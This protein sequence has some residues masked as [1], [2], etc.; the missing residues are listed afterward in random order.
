MATG[1]HQMNAEP[2]TDANRLAYTF[3]HEAQRPGGSGSRTQGR[4]CSDEKD[5][6][7]RTDQA[8]TP[9]SHCPLGQKEGKERVPLRRRYMTRNTFQ[10][11]YVF[12]RMTGHGK[13]HF[14]RYRVRSTDGKWRHLAETVNPPRRKD[15]ERILAER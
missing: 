7:R 2:L 8:W 15:A 10:K 4:P 1:S 9:S 6:T 11:G 13:V 12:V 3:S 14:I 5:D